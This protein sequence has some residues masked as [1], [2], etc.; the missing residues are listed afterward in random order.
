MF[1]AL[2]ISTGTSVGGIGPNK[3]AFSGASLPFVDHLPHTH[4][5]E[6]M[7]F[8]KGLPHWGAH[9]ADDLERIVALHDASSIA[10]VIVEPV[11]GKSHVHV[12]EVQHYALELLQRKIESSD[13]YSDV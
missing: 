5:L 4:N 3:K 6:H 1:C 11:A 2:Y 7:A 8:S 10:A 13:F 9:L 12:L